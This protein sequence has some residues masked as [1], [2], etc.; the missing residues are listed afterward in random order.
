MKPGVRVYLPLAIA[1]TLLVGAPGSPTLGQ[2]PATTARAAKKQSATS[3]VSRKPYYANTPYDIIPYHRMAIRPYVENFYVTPQK[4]LGPGRE[5]AEPKVTTV[6]IGFLGPAEGSGPL[7]AFGKQ[8]LQGAKLAIEQAN[9]GGGYKGKPFDLVVHEDKARWGD[10]SNTMVKMACDEM[11]WGVLGT[12]DSANSHVMMRV[13]LK[14]P[15]PIVNSATTDQTLMEHRVPFI[16][17]VIPDDRQY[18]YATALY[19]FQ[20]KHFRNVGLIRPNNRDGRFAVRKLIDA[21]RQ[22]GS[23]ILEEVR[24]N[25]GD[26]DF[27]EQ[28]NHLQ[29]FPLDAV[30]VWG[31]PKETALIVRQM[32]RMGM[33]QPVVGWFRAVSPVLLQQGGPDVEGMVCAYP[34]DPGTRDAVLRDFQHRYQ[35]RFG[36]SP[37]AFAAYAYDG[38]SVLVASIRKKGLNR[39]RIADGMAELKSF[40]GATGELIFD[41]ARN[42]VCPIYLAE[43]KHGQFVFRPATRPGPPPATIALQGASR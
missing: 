6:K 13:A 39:I 37:D 2:K 28:L 43:V 5:V 40:H 1:A 19:L 31:N 38:M 8:M 22:L 42:N 33:K 12:L 17:R 3:P 30:A 9:A 36:M 41:G 32:R 18:S 7:G 23:P 21:A 14:F 27:T 10:S 25:D 11:V 4:W 26:T 20:E 16:L 15:M 34:Y 29:G 24:Y 35:Q